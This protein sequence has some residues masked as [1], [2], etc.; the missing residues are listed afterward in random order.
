MPETIFII[1]VT[2]LEVK[3]AAAEFNLPAFYLA[4]VFWRTRKE[5]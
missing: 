5:W 3:L 1:L 2:R 4:T